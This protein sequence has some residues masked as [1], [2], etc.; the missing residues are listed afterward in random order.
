MLIFTWNLG[1]SERALDLA[2]TYLERAA[3]SETVLACLQELPS[4]LPPSNDHLTLGT[5]G[6]GAAVPVLA[7]RR[8]LFVHSASVACV[9]SWDVAQDRMQ[10][11]RWQL[12]SGIEFFAAGIH[13]ID[14]RNY[15]IPEVRG[16]Y[17]ALTRRALD[18]RWIDG[19]PL[20]MLGDFNATPELP[21]LSERACLF[22]V[23]STYDHRPRNET[24]FGRTSPPLYRIEPSPG[25]ARGTYFHISDSNWRDLDH[26]YVSAALVQGAQARRL[27]AIGS[28]SLVTR[29]GRPSSARFSD[30]LPVEAHVALA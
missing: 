5:R 7:R 26:V 4:P 1:K 24:F 10:I 30:H 27:D 13:G 2:L 12:S 29:T 22:G 8:A 6:L 9:G 11:A 14:R 20:L 28:T 21:E 18:E 15:T 16:A 17:A 23:S 3:A 19:R 25:V